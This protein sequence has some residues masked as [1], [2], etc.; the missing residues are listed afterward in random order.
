MPTITDKSDELLNNMDPKW[1][2][3]IV[4]RSLGTGLLFIV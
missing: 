1:R 3:I 2:P 4:V